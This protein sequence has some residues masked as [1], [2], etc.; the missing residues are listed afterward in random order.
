MTFDEVQ[1]A[2]RDKTP[3]LLDGVAHTVVKYMTPGMI[4]VQ[5]VGG[6]WAVKVMADQLM[7]A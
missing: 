6:G 3:V 1:Q 2:G 7:A 5:P 4:F